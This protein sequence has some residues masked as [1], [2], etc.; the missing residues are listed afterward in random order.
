MIWLILG[1]LVLGIVGGIV[2]W[3]QYGA[4]GRRK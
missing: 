1:V 3:G 4:H 2:W